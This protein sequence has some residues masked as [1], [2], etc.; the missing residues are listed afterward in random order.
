MER[1]L[2]E[3]FRSSRSSSRTCGRVGVSAIGVVGVS[4]YRR[5]GVSAYRRVGVSA[6]RRVGECSVGAQSL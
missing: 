6:C 3:E 2:M 1:S 5:I 4:A